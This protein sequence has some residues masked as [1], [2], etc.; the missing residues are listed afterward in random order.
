[1][2]INYA[3]TKKIN[4]FIKQN[5]EDQEA[6]KFLLDPMNFRDF[7]VGLTEA[8]T[9]SGYTEDPNNIKLKTKYL[10]SKLKSI[11]SSICSKTIYSWFNGDRRPKIEPCSRKRMF[12]ICFA[13][14]F[15]YDDVKWFFSHVYFDRCFNYHILE[16]AIYFYCFKHNYPYSKALELIA[17]I[18]EFPEEVQTHPELEG[19]Y[20]HILQEKLMRIDSEEELISFL[21]TQK[22][23]FHIWNQSALNMINS[24]VNNIRGSKEKNFES[25]KKLIA[26]KDSTEI[27]SSSLDDYGLIV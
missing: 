22:S 11:G 9:K 8:I 14:E 1:M 17:I 12:E 26:E 15:S 10:S 20:T 24:F 4:D 3:Y 18:Q 7:S 13:L 21:N 23:N 6:I 19:N 5:Y 2:T 25:I 27:I 16:E